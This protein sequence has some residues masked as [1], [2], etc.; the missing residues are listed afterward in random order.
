MLAVS[1]E[2]KGLILW[3]NDLPSCYLK[4]EKPLPTDFDVLRGRKLDYYDFYSSSSWR[5]QLALLLLRLP[6]FR[7]HHYLFFAQLF[8][9]TPRIWQQKLTAY[10]KLFLN[11]PMTKHNWQYC[12]KDKDFV[13]NVLQPILKGNVDYGFTEDELAS[14][15]MAQ[16]VDRA[17]TMQQQAEDGGGGETQNVLDELTGELIANRPMNPPTTT[18]L[19]KKRRLAA[20]STIQVQPSTS[21]DH[22]FMAVKLENNGDESNNSHSMMMMI[23]D[24]NSVG[25]NDDA[26]DGD[27]EA[28]EGSWIAEIPPGETIRARLLKTYRSMAYYGYKRF[29]LPELRTRLCAGLLALHVDPDGEA[30]ARARILVR[31]EQSRFSHPERELMNL[32]GMLTEVCGMSQRAAYKWNEMVPKND[33]Y[34]YRKLMVKKDRRAMLNTDLDFRKK[35]LEE[36]KAAF[37]KFEVKKPPNEIIEIPGKFMGYYPHCDPL[38]IKILKGL[39]W[40]IPT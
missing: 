16:E 36:A 13:A 25:A 2:L 17:R 11:E 7:H 18:P 27:N 35:K 8:Q 23:D 10:E 9:Q 29:I 33:G 4:N 5:Q 24:G 26:A 31:H 3:V 32:V 37:T 12:P 1:P 39:Q 20:A 15:A 28:K 22:H 38:I 6:H 40:G 34:S 19:R 14:L 21:D 30:P